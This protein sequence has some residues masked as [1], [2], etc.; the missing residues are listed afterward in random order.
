M[1]EPAQLAKS[2]REQ[3]AAALNALQSNAHVPDELMQL[4]EPIADAMSVLHR[5]ERS[6]G[7][8]LDDRDT[9]LVAVRTALDN[10]Q[11]VTIHHP[12]IEMVMKTITTSLSKMHTL[13]QYTPPTPAPTPT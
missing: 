8:V 10:L 7:A 5:I 3:L 4:A 6:N 12:T 13:N 11:K 1:S 2:A 9:A